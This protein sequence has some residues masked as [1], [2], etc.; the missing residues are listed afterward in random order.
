[1]LELLFLVYCFYTFFW[2][3]S[4]CHKY[5]SFEGQH[6]SLDFTSLIFVKSEEHLC[7]SLISL[8][9]CSW[10]S[11]LC[12]YFKSNFSILFIML[13]SAKD[14]LLFMI[15]LIWCFKFSS[16]SLGQL[17]SK[18]KVFGSLVK[19][20]SGVKNLLILFLLLLLYHLQVVACQIN[21][22]IFLYHSSFLI[23]RFFFIKPAI[24][25]IVFIK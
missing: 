16:T 7:S 2:Y 9:L 20:L 21:L 15:K 5:I 23:S 17:K 18:Q 3:F 1:M 25:I 8:F 12:L 22:H 10:I 24:I 6:V 19:S 4:S 14:S 11:C 13:F